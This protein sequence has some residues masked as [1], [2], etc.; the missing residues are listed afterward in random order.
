V[1]DYRVAQ[2]EKVNIDDPVASTATAAQCDRG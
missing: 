1:H 2:D